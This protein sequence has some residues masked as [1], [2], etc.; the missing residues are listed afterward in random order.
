MT[1]EI[2][3]MNREA[4]AM[5]A[6]SA[7]TLPQES[8]PK[9]FASANKI[10]ALSPRRPIGMMV[11]GAASF[12]DVPWDTIIKMYRVHLTNRRFD[13]LRGYV[14]DFVGF[15]RKCR[16]CWPA[17]QQDAYVRRKVRSYFLHVREAIEARIEEAIQKK[18]RVLE[19]EVR[20]I[21]VEVIG[22]HHALWKAAPQAPGISRPALR[23][24][25]SQH[26]AAVDDVKRRVF[27]KLPL[28]S[29]RSRLLGELAINLFARFP[30]GLSYQQSG[31]VVAGFGEAEVFPS[32]HQL[33]FEGMVG[34]VLKY[35]EH[36]TCS[37]SFQNSA[38]IVP[39]AQTEMVSSFMEGVDPS[40]EQAIEKDMSEILSVFPDVVVDSIPGM[41]N[42][43]RKSLKRKLRGV[44]KTMAKEYRANLKTYRQ[45][46]FVDP[47]VQVVAMLP[48]DELAAMAEALVNLT[49]FKRRVS[50]QAETVG[51]PIDV[52][53]ISK[54]DGLVWVKRKHYFPAEL[55][56]D[57][58]A[59]KT[60]GAH[61]E[62]TGRAR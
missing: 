8:A 45:K 61:D 17:S 12:M 14:D 49:S 52:A 16:H 4:I 58:L 60:K 23:K 10:F 40:Y 7:V 48:K 34:S 56:P 18:G 11:F 29:T 21:V 43:E 30:R 26:K 6:D 46:Q 28:D 3:V 19:S 47:V 55:N 38:T 20:E 33:F 24:R 37:V 36:R 25:L 57:F 51:G 5:A 39:F 41:E 1:A 2:A 42:G 9:I 35:R 53:V 50:M 44:G 27:E 32:L 15:V 59:R 62:D 31:V 22:V 54:G 13:T